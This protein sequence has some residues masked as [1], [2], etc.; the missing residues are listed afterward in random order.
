M[1]AVFLEINCVMLETCKC[2]TK[3]FNYQRT[4]SKTEQHDN[5]FGKNIIFNYSNRIRANKLS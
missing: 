4:L 3:V 5:G 1:T 2:V